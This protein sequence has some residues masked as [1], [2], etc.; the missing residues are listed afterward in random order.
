MES[1]HVRKQDGSLEPSH[2]PYSDTKRLLSVSSSFLMLAGAMLQSVL[3]LGHNS[4][5]YYC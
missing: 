4:F 3:L 2:A 5:D 1:L